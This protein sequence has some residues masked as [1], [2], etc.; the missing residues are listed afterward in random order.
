MTPSLAKNE[1]AAVQAMRFI[2]ALLVVLQHAFA[3]GAYVTPADLGWFWRLQFGALGVCLF[4]VISGFIMSMKLDEAPAS[5]LAKRFLRIY[6]SFWL[7]AALSLALQYTVIGR[8][9]T[10]HL[11]SL[12]L[13]PSTL[14]DNSLQIPF[15]TLRYEVVFY[16]LCGVAC[17]LRGVRAYVPF[18][19]IVWLVAIQINDAF[20]TPV[21]HPF[22]SAGNILLSRMNIYFIAGALFGIY[23]HRISIPLWACIPLSVIGYLDICSLLPFSQHL[24]PGAYHVGSAISCSMMIYTAMK[25]GVSGVVGRVLARLGDY[26]YGIYLAHLPIIFTMCMI[27][28]ESKWTT[29]G[30][31]A[32]LAAVSIPAAILLGH[33]E[34]AFHRALSRKLL[35]R[36]STPEAVRV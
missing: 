19:L 10:P 24:S 15:W 18:A 20:G 17:L 33:G 28:H 35:A 21:S 5:F 4:F 32:A 1:S 34:H 14:D 23:R 12:F 31:I 26:S 16:L 22:P 6:P 27:M 11:S 29:A 3:L 13:V 2:A 8:F 7:F 36:R 25:L 9:V 30:A